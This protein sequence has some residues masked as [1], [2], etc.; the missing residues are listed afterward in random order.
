MDTK[1]INKII[2]KLYRIVQKSGYSGKLYRDD[3]WSGL[4]SIREIVQ[5]VLPPGF[6]LIMNHVY[7]YT[8][9]GNSKEYQFTVEHEETGE[10]IIDGYIT[11]HA[12]GNMNDKWS[13]YDITAQ[14]AK[15]NNTYTES[16]KMK[17]KLVR[18]TES[19]LHRIVNESVRKVLREWNN[20]YEGNDLTYDSI[21]MQAEHIIP[22]MEQN[23]EPISWRNVA[24]QM[25]FRLETL[26]GDDMEL[27][28]DTIEEV[29]MYM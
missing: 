14:W 25:G 26:N 11:A 29:M 2:N 3:D 1:E 17:K 8:Q 24:K 6:R 12:A 9:D 28:K 7:G 18:L 27:L 20:D 13:A 5:P 22:Q 21:K 10:Q 19:D 15:H 16:N 4:F 23:G